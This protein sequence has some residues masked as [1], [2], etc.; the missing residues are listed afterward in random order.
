MRAS[1]LP[2]CLCCY[3][4]LF[5]PLMSL[6]IIVSSEMFLF[7]GKRCRMCLCNIYDNK[8]CNLRVVLTD[9]TKLLQV[10]HKWRSGARPEVKNQG[11][12]STS[13]GEKTSILPRI[14]IHQVYIRSLLANLSWFND[15]P[16]FHPEPHRNPF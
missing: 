1:L 11:T 14:Q 4:P 3:H 13:Q 16:D 15:I 2:Q 9:T 10:V 7:P 5:H 6:Y 8:I 12:T